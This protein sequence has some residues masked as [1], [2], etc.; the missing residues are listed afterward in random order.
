MLET[1]RSRATFEGELKQ[2][3]DL[4][5]MIFRSVVGILPRFSFLSNLPAMNSKHSSQLDFAVI[6]PGRLV[7][8]APRVV[9]VTV[10]FGPMVRTAEHPSDITDG[11]SEKADEN[12]ACCGKP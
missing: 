5:R 7:P 12:E 8:N 2:T 10:S 9:A 11:G 4:P 1:S 3:V 6:V